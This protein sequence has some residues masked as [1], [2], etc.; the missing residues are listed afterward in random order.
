M[1]K[2]Y[3]MSPSGLQ[4]ATACVQVHTLHVKAKQHTPC[5][6][7]SS[8]EMVNKCQNLR[9][10]NLPV[11]CHSSFTARCSAQVLYSLCNGL[12]IDFNSKCKCSISRSNEL[13]H[14][15]SLR[16]C[17][18]HSAL[19]FILFNL[20]IGTVHTCVSSALLARLYKARYTNRVDYTTILNDCTK[21]HPQSNIWLRNCFVPL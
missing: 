3:H 2:L 15:M 4:V 13:M 20:M 7:H 12:R 17:T 8:R 21:L 1:C 18:K 9:A 6:Y 11:C 10:E 19:R 5:L 14:K 16:N